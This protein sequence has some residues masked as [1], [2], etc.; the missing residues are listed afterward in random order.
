MKKSFVETIARRKQ[1]ATGLAAV[2]AIVCLAPAAAAQESKRFAT[3]N[4]GGTG[5]TI[6]YKALGEADDLTNAEKYQV[7]RALRNGEGHMASAGVES[8]AGLGGSCK[9]K[10]FLGIPDGGDCTLTADPAATKTLS[11]LGS[12]ALT[13]AICLVLDVED[14]ELTEPF[15]DLLLEAIVKSTLEPVIDQCA[16]ADQTTELSIDFQLVPPKF[17]ANAR[18]E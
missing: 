17:K 16:D 8:V 4:E 1:L 10:K 6:N 11:S 18:C 13:N 5:Y 2:L 12:F 7:A 15:C 9:I 3:P 14:G